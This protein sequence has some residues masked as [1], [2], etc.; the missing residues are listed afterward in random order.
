MAQTVQ[1][2]TGPAHSLRV[3]DEVFGRLNKIRSVLEFE[4]GRRLTLNDTLKEALGWVE[5][6]PPFIKMMGGAGYTTAGAG[7][8]KAPRR[9]RSRARRKASTG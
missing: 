2:R 5:E 3:D 7:G 8:A 4:S 9:S 6:A 1:S